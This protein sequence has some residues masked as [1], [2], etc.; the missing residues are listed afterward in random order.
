MV[1]RVS[2]SRELG[3]WP[4]GPRGECRPPGPFAASPSSAGSL[5]RGGG[6]LPLLSPPAGR[7]EPAIAAAGLGRATIPAV[8][9]AGR[10]ATEPEVDLPALLGA[11][12]FTIRT[13]PPPGDRIGSPHERQ[14]SRECSSNPL[15]QQQGQGSLS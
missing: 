5:R 15:G 8:A 1:G 12:F 9:A 14:H 3:E 7:T 2:S 13:C 10:L 11:P 6:D 4:P